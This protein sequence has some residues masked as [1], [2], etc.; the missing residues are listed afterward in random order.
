[1]P[2][3]HDLA[4][5]M[6]VD[7]PIHTAPTTNSLLTM[8]EWYQAHLLPALV[9]RKM[10][11]EPTQLVSFPPHRILEELR[12]CQLGKFFLGQRRKPVED[13]AKQ[14]RDVVNS[15]LNDGFYIDLVAVRT[16]GITYS[17]SGVN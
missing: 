11:S 15:T 16:A 5:L 8:A 9:H 10:R 12:K 3:S 14:T 17:R 7:Q 13:V 1:M 4:L 6:V 2:S